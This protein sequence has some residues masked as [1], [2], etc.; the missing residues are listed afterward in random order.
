[1]GLSDLEQPNDSQATAKKHLVLF[2]IITFVLSYAYSAFV[3]MSGGVKNFGIAGL[4]LMM[5]I[6]GLV[7]LVY[8]KFSKIGFRDVGWKIGSFKYHLIALVCPIV[9]ALLTNW[10]ATLFSIREFSL[11]PAAAWEKFGPIVIVSLIAGIVGALGEELGWRGFLVPKIFDTKIRFPLFAT[12]IIWALWHLPMVVFGGYYK[13]G[14]PLMIATTYAISIIGI[15]YFIGWLRMVSGSVW[16]ATMAHTSHNFFFQL[17]VP[18]VLFAK[19]GTNAKWWEVV[20]ADAGIVP[21]LLYLMLIVFGYR[22]LKLRVPA[23][24]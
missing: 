24:E 19:E 5:W 20:G 17:F 12:G 2:L 21:A 9:L 10:I 6:P 18:Y 11:L 7:S 23:V 15:G 16:V 13:I 3:I 4:V 14:E 1:M 8:R 22:M